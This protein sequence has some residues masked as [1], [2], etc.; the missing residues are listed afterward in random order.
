[1]E[2]ISLWAK[3]RRGAIRLKAS[4]GIKTLADARALLAAGATRLGTSTAAGLLAELQGPPRP[5]TEPP[6]Y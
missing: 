2:Q 4:G 1:M 3:H 6:S 5:G